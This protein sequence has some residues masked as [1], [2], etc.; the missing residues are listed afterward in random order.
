MGNGS[1]CGITEETQ[2][3]NGYNVTIEQIMAHKVVVGAVQNLGNNTFQTASYSNYGKYVDV[4]APGSSIYS[5]RPDDT[6]GLGSGTSMAAPHVTGALAYI[7]SLNPDLTGTEVKNIMLDN[8]SIQVKDYSASN[9]GVDSYPM[10]DLY[11]ASKAVVDGSEEGTAVYFDNSVANWNQ[12]Y[13]YVWNNSTDSKVF[14]P[15]YHSPRRVGN[16]YNEC[17]I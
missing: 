11:L 2:L 3:G 9:S 6:Y 17:R 8:T 10:V 12:V 7:W 15:A 4:V 14:T 5:A 1:F 16:L 13:A